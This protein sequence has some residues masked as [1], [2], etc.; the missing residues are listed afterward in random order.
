MKE[1]E[2]FF[3]ANGI[4]ETVENTDRIKVI[5]LKCYRNGYLSVQMED[6]TRS[7]GLLLKAK[8]LF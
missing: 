4:K 2:I 8:T 5:L 6:Y 3:T 7:E 1:L